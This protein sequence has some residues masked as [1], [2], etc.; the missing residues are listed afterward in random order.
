MF[1]LVICNDGFT[2]DTCETNVDDCDPNPCM[3]GGSCEDGIESFT[4]TCAAGF[5][6]DTCEINVNDCDPN[7]CMSGGSCEDG[8]D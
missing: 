2:G 7:P 5:M 3:N 6:G 1:C 4:C 8:I